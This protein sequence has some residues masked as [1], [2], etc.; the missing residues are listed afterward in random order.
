MQAVERSGCGVLI[1]SEAATA[2]TIKDAV[3][4]IQAE[5]RY[6]RN[7]QALQVKLEKVDARERFSAFLSDVLSNR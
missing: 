1:R 2:K 7:A 3:G 6:Q 5:K 4:A